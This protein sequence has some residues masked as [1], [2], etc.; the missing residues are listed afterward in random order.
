M[1]L[2]LCLGVIAI[3][4]IAFERMVRSPWGRVL[5]AIRDD[6]VAAAALGKNVFAFRLQ[7]FVVGSSVMGVAGALYA[8]FQG[9]IS[10]SDFLPIFTFQVF[11]MLIVGGAAT[12]WGRCWAACWCG[13]CGR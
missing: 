3:V 10:P 8:G 2:L 6:E 13:S 1:Y 11:V 5:R 4:Y 9:F 12:T 7:S